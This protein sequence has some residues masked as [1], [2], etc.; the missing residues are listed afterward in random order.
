MKRVRIKRILT[1]KD[2][3]TKGSYTERILIKRVLPEDSI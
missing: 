3:Y 1:K 2:P